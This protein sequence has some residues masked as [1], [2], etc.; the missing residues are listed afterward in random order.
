MPPG[1][2]PEDETAPVLEPTAE[3]LA[4]AARCIRE[5]GVVVAPSD[6]NLALTL[7]PWNSEAVD[8]AYGIKKRPKHKPLTLF[9]RD[10]GDWRRYGTHDDPALVDRLVQRFWPGPLNLV[11]EAT[12]RVDDERLRRDGTVAIGC[13][14]NPT[15]RGLVSRVDGPVAMTSANRSGTVA[16]DT[17]VDVD[18]ALEHVGVA[19]D[20]VVA[21][22]PQGTTRASTIVD[23]TGVGDPE[24]L[25]R[26]D[27][28]MA[29]VEAVLD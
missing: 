3:N 11:V 6:T 18:L 23:C 14:S 24:L 9:V 16:D 25:R 4:T 29:D 10:P 2:G 20:Y 12:D 17:L 13:L 21:G 15:W 8:R 7:D 28:T 19:V 5:G 26:G 22:E 27:V 1:T